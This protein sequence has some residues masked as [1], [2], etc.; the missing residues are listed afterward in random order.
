MAS[1]ITLYRLFIASPSDIEIEHQII[2][3]TVSEWNFLHGEKLQAN[4]EV[5]S[6]LSNSYSEFGDTPQSIINRQLF[7]SSDI[8]VGV[9][10]TRFGSPTEDDDSG[11]E[12]ELKRGISQSKK[13][14]LYFSEKPVAPSLIN[15]EGYKRIQ[16]FKEDFKSKGLYFT[17]Q[18]E[19]DFEKLFRKHLSLLMNKLAPEQEKESISKYQE[20]VNKVGD[21]EIRYCRKCGSERPHKWIKRSHD[22]FFYTERYY[23]FLLVCDYCGKEEMFYTTE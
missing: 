8:I 11:T 15:S 19:G 7:D 2:R 1:N 17:F 3:N 20:F 9:F 23:E 6:W 21:T 14:M 12:G 13:V 18:N 22:T 5:V 16:E 4:I 10:W